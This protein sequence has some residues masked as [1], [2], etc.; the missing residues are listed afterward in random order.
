MTHQE[1][2]AVRLEL[3]EQL[4]NKLRVLEN[5]CYDGYCAIKKPAPGQ[6]HTNGG[7]RCLRHLADDLLEMAALSERIPRFGVNRCWDDVLLD[8]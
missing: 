3:I 7:C 8:G 5:G 4:K 2:N 6:M 1:N